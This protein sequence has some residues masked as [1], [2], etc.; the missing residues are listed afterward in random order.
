M[1]IAKWRKA[2]EKII[3]SFLV[4]A[5]ICTST[6]FSIHAKEA[7]TGTENVVYRLSEDEIEKATQR[8]V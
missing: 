6:L 8:C 1:S 4:L 7:K 3:L 5:A 2:Y